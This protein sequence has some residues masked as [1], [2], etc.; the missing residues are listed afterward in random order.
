M[1]KMRICLAD[2]H[3]LFGDGVAQLL[4]KQPDMEVV[5]IARDGLEILSL[6][7]ELKPDLILMDIHMP[8]SD[9]VEATYLIRE[10]DTH[11]TIVMLTALD[12]DE[13]LIEAIR[14]GADGYML[15]NTGSESFMAAVRGALKGETTVPPHLTRRLLKEFS[16][17]A[18]QPRRPVPSK[19]A[20]VLTFREVQVLER[21]A[22][23]ASNQEIAEQLGTS[24]YT[25][26]SH[27]RNLLSKLGAENRWEAA[28]LAEEM[29]LLRTRR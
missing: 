20:P 15:K 28:K 25:A 27:V 6:A 29:G 1:P 11:V 17:L 24:L 22:D 4:N 19:G 21:I 5:G 23:G 3:E 16:A 10:F 8:I 13:K 7:R 14:A 9:G 12:S 2:D 26:K 18:N